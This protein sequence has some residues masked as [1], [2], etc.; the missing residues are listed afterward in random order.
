MNE[1]IRVLN[2]ETEV[3]FIDDGSTDGTFDILSRLKKSNDNVRIIRFTRN[4][5]QTAAMSAGFD[6]ATGEIIV[7]MDGDLQNDPK[8]IP[9][10]IEK[11][12][13]GYDIVSGWRVN[14]Q[15]RLLSRKIPSRVANW[16]IGLM[17]GVKLHDSGCSL[18][19]Y[20]SHVVKNLRLYGEMH[21]FIPALASSRGARI[22]EV[23]V[24]HHPRRRGSSKYGISRTIRVI[25]D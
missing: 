13:E 21:R 7:T 16:L 20:R 19:G 18:K 17:T 4:F 11:I 2:R 10:L 24:N 23:K 9:L 1:T 8:D 25:L 5:G 14:R 12:E 22:A 6:Y 3:I 15:D